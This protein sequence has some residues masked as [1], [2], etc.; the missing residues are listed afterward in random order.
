MY[1]R[2]SGK[3]SRGLL[4]A[5]HHH[6]YGYGQ[7]TTRTTYARHTH[8]TRTAHARHTHGTRTAHARHTHSVRTHLEGKATTAGTEGC[9]ALPAVIAVSYA[10]IWLWSQF[11]YLSGA[12]SQVQTTNDGAREWLDCRRSWHTNAHA[13]MIRTCRAGK[14]TRRKRT[15]LQGW[16]KSLRHQDT[17]VL[18]CAPFGFCSCRKVFWEIHRS[19]RPNRELADHLV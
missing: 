19:G 18:L 17:Y 9:A 16:R 1:C 2:Q 3:T 11:S 5:Q 6:A 13:H 12:G 14:R 8:G 7:R 10:A 15:V 4:L